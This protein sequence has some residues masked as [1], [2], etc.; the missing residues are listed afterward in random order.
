[1]FKLGTK[2]INFNK[3]ILTD[4]TKNKKIRSCGNKSEKYL[5]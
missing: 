4:Q 3:L 2:T 5:D 1:M